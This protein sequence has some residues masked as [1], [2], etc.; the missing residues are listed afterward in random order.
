[1]EATIQVEQSLRGG[2]ETIQMTDVGE[3]GSTRKKEEQKNKIREPPT[4]VRK[5]WNF[6]YE[7]HRPTKKYP[8]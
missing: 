5:Q 6:L 8:S 1:M 2:A 4:M 7:F 3:M